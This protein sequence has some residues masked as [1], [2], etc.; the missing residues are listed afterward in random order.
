[1]ADDGDLQERLRTLAVPELELLGLDLV[2]FDLLSGGN[3]FTLRFSLE[4]HVDEADEPVAEEVRRVSVS[5][6][7]EASR[8]IARAI[9][10][11]EAAAGEFLGRYTIEV[12]SPGIFRRL[13]RP[14]HFRRYVGEKIK[15]SAEVDGRNLQFRGR[16]AEAGA[17]ELVIED[18]KRGTVELAYESV[19]RANL[20][21]DLDFGRKSKK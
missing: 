3:R 20:D 1:M 9:E 21:P 2:E 15:A 10:A 14:E 11:E 16:L 13:S 5:D 6:C 19:R 4:R 18:E 7:A 12:S 17:H 8:A